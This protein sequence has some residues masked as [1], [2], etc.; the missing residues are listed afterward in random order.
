M[1]FCFNLRMHQW[2]VHNPRTN[3]DGTPMGPSSSY[4]EKIIDAF[5]YWLRF[6]FQSANR[7][8]IGKFIVLDDRGLSS[9]QPVSQVEGTL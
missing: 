1:T 3:S 7:D 5:S 8:D 6:E 2:Y 9:A 4:L